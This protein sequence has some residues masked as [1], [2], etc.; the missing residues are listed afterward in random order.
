MVTAAKTPRNAICF[1]N[2]I[3]LDANKRDHSFVAPAVSATPEQGGPTL[4]ARALALIHLAMHDAWFGA[5][6]KP[7]YG[8]YLPGFALKPS[9][10]PVDPSAAAGA[11]ARTMLDELYRRQAGDTAAAWT[12]FEGAYPTPDAAVAYGVRVASALLGFRGVDVPPPGSYAP[13]PC[14]QGRDFHRVDP[15]NP[16]QGYYGVTHGGIRPFVITKIRDLDDPR[17]FEPSVFPNALA[18]VRAVGGAPGQ[19]G[20][21]RSADETVAALFW[22]FDGANGLG[23]PPRLYNQILGCIADSQKNSPDDDA[24]LFALANTAMADGGISAWSNKYRLAFWRPVLG[25]REEDAS[26]GPCGKPRRNLGPCVDPF[27]KPLGA[28]ST[29][30]DRKPFT[31][32]FPA[33]PSGH[34][35]FGSAAFQSARRF[36]AAKN[37]KKY[38]WGRREADSLAFEFVSGELDGMAEQPLGSVRPQ[39]LRSFAGLWDAL[40]ENALSRLWLGVHWVFDSFGDPD[41]NDNV[42]GVPL[43]LGVADEI[44]DSGLRAIQE[45]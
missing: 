42:G 32:N 35:T 29:N 16:K 17:R 14:S 5:Q 8:L 22:A 3:A 1:W 7:A 21:T 18:Q 43:G 36:Y 26:T 11:A 30:T 9:P 34:A 41:Y 13:P 28:P 6:K 23:T 20:T 12:A 27:W 44:A 25:V 37:P 19:P 45:P 31:P 24:R 15:E 33:Y 10:K 38:P 40:R 4:S 2:G 39:V